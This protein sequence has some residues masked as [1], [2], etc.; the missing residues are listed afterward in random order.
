MGKG[1]IVELLEKLFGASWRTSL[2]GVLAFLTEAANL[3]QQY[4]VQMSVPTELLH[5]SA[6]FFGLIALMNAKD[7]GVTGT[8]AK[9]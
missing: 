1:L 8:V 3:I 4:L 2:F 9:E 6:L 7:K 5:T